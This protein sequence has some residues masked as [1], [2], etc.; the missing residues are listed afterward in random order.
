MPWAKRNDVED[1]RS[2]QLVIPSSDVKNQETKLNPRPWLDQSLT[3]NSAV[4]LK[5]KIRGVVAGVPFKNGVPKA[6]V[7]L[8]KTDNLP[9]KRSWICAKPSYNHALD[10]KCLGN[11]PTWSNMF[12]ICVNVLKYPSSSWFWLIRQVIRGAFARQE[13]IGM[14]LADSSGCPRPPRQSPS[15]NQD[16]RGIKKQHADQSQIN[17]NTFVPF[18]VTIYDT[19]TVRWI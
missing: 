6:L 7:G 8:C 9:K 10:L 15:R 2:R 5:S 11:I 16:Q 13:L 18:H 12:Q 14:L 3:M 17:A 1:K 19:N 4:R